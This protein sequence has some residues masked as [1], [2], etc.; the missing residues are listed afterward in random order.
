[1]LTPA[2]QRLFTSLSVF[3][4]G[5][6]LAGAEAIAGAGEAAEADVLD[7]LQSLLDKSLIRRSEDGGGEPRYRM[8]ET[9]REYGL[10]R[11]KA[12]G[13]ADVREWHAHFYLAL[14]EQAEAELKGER[15]ALWLARLENEYDNL[16]AALRW[17]QDHG[18]GE[19]TLRF[20][21]ALWRFW[22]VR[23]YLSES[24]GWIR[25]ALAATDRPTAD[26][27]RL[28]ARALNGAGN[29]AWAQSDFVTARVCHETA[30]AIW[31]ALAD[32]RGL[33]T[34]LGNLGIVAKAQGDYPTA[35]A[36]HERSLALSRRLDDRL[37][38]A[39]SL[40]NLALVADLQGDYDTARVLFEESL[41][42]RRALSDERGVA[43]IVGNLGFLAYHQGDMQQARL[44]IE[45][46][47]ALQRRLGAR[48][49][50]ANALN[51]MGNVAHCDGR[52]AAARDL[53]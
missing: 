45:E 50:I 17:S 13:E 25:A 3:V 14:A 12:S 46:S 6:S 16:R 15:Q 47:L 5:F 48:L 19:M 35:R 49:G 34:S 11:L 9:I 7:G 8:L 31:Q 37:S 43:T 22:W 33:A 30:L 39:F 36:F 32:D 21:G 51:D 18:M 1:M 41:A 38:V 44:L 28:R 2:E 53:Y 23:G 24:V 20:I 26:Y 42:L 40:N 29:L 4:G 52:W 10:E 27:Q